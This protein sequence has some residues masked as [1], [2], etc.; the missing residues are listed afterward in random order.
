MPCHPATGYSN[1]FSKRGDVGIFTEFREHF[2]PSKPS[3]AIVQKLTRNFHFGDGVWH[4]IG[5]SSEFAV[6]CDNEAVNSEFASPAIEPELH[7]FH[8]RM[9]NDSL[10][11]PFAHSVKT[12]LTLRLCY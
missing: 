7:L 2:L 8:L 6:R 4:S 5:D 1:Q 10:S 3:Y 9:D 11:E 12:L